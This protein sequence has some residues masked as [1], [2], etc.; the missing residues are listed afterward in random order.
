MYFATKILISALLIGVISE[1]AKRNTLAG[2]LTASLP[3]I[4]LFA[5]AWLYFE[6]RDTQKIIALSY[7][8]FWL[9]LPSLAFFLAL[10]ALLKLGMRFGWALLIST[11]VTV[12]M[13]VIFIFLL[14]KMGIN[15]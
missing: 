12:L 7:D 1:L 14:K 8:I 11:A 6:T 9:V 13:Y 15:S 10:P 5:I 4:S 2:A 3:F